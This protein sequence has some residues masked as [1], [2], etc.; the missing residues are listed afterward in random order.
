MFRA[1]MAEQ[2][3]FKP[4]FQQPKK[5][6]RH[7]VRIAE[8]DIDGS[9]PLYTALRKIR[10]VSFMFSNAICHTCGINRLKIV[11]ELTID[12]IK[13]LE[14]ILLDPVSYGIPNWMMNRRKEYEKG[15][16]LHMIG[17]DLRV[18][19]DNDIKLMKKIRCYKGVRHMIGQPVRGQST[20][21]NF[22]KNKG[23]SGLGVTRAKTAA[24]AAKDAGAKG[25]D[26]GG[27]KK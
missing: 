3:S 2:K 8:T 15:V 5:D 4:P 10:G 7:I 17:T 1:K 25:G 13:K 21:S 26:K 22:R 11:G 16:D 12:E 14:S 23:K 18:Q 20:K 27:K 19:V 6:Y 24:P 9:R